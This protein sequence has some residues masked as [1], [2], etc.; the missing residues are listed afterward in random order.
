[1]N[2]AMVLGP[3]V[4]HADLHPGNLL[5]VPEGKLGL[6][7][8]GATGDASSERLSAAVGAV[9]DAV[10]AGDP[11]ALTD[12]VLLMA[13][14]VGDLDRPG[15]TKDLD[16]SLLRPLS[17]ESLGAV[18]AAQ[19]LKDLV[20]LMRRHGL[21]VNPQMTALVR[22]VVTCESTA[23]GLDP[24]LSFRKVVVPFLVTRAMG[25]PAYVVDPG[26]AGS[27]GSGVAPGP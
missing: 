7:D 25:F 10:F 24:Q 6:L 3:S 18:R 22:A 11:E 14:P 4:F 13:T 26:D 2:L 12:G 1:A 5:A 23:R 20:G 21:R 15:L 27:G 19:L 17:S 16:A 8:F 9:M